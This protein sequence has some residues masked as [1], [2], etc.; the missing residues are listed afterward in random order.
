MKTAHDARM[1]HAL[2]S[3]SIKGKQQQEVIYEGQACANGEGSTH[4][5]DCSENQSPCSAKID[6]FTHTHLRSD[7]MKH[8]ISLAR[9][10]K[11][12]MESIKVES[13]RTF[14]DDSCSQRIVA[15]Y[16]GTVARASMPTTTREQKGTSSL[17]RHGF[18]AGHHHCAFAA[19]P[20]SQKGESS[21]VRRQR[22]CSLP[23]KLMIRSPQT[24]PRLKSSSDIP[25][26][27]VL[28]SNTHSFPRKKRRMGEQLDG[29]NNARLPM[30]ALVAGTKSFESSIDNRRPG[31]TQ[32]VPQSSCPKS[33]RSPTKN[34]YHVSPMDYYESQDERDKPKVLL[35][36]SY[37]LER[38][39][40][41]KESWLD[42][43][44]WKPL[45]KHLLAETRRRHC[46]QR[47]KFVPKPNTEWNVKQLKGWLTE[48]PIH[49]PQ[50]LDRI[51]QLMA[52]LKMSV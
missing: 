20:Q 11:I 48:N 8:L 50:D 1:T 19:K 34:S 5:D 46:W 10:E 28:G 38:C 3:G 47:M 26:E 39:N 25:R 2:D 45:K 13:S 4:S 30:Q 43:P 35:C 32:N 52:A 18:R 31:V 44:E 14:G 49:D 27:G 33:V 40:F 16:P 22:Y 29:S 42:R 37:P 6:S 12:R 7:W 51:R 36:L 24:K 21:N 17:G 15:P 41:D 9:K 23:Q